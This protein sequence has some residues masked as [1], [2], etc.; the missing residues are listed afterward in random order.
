MLKNP[1]TLTDGDDVDL[2]FDG[3]RYILFVIIKFSEVSSL[4][5][6]TF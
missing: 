3:E 1:F 5:N 6:M 2:W 4:Y